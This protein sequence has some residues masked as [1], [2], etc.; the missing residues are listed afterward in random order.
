MVGREQKSGH[1]KRSPDVVCRDEVEGCRK[2][3]VLCAV[4]DFVR[5]D[6]KRPGSLRSD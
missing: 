4:F 3:T 2:K 1:P 6:K 5:P